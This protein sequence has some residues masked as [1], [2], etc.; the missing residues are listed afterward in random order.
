MK[1]QEE[2]ALDIKNR[3]TEYCETKIPRSAGLGTIIGYVATFMIREIASNREQLTELERRHE[4][5]IE[6]VNERL[7]K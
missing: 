1:T 2:I 7:N 5:F 6:S 3:F 4:S